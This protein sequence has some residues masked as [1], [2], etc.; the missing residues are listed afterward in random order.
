[1]GFRVANFGVLTVDG[2][3]VGPVLVGFRS[4][5]VHFA[6]VVLQTELCRARRVEGTAEL[7]RH[8]QTIGHVQPLVEVRA[9]RVAQPAKHLPKAVGASTS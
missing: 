9:V 5:R 3:G 7:D 6:V 8:C 2:Q 1:M 4:A